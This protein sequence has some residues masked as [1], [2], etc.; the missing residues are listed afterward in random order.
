MKSTSAKTMGFVG[1]IN[2]AQG[3]E[4]CGAMSVMG[5]KFARL[6]VRRIYPKA[7]GPSN[8]QE[9]EKPGTRRVLSL[10]RIIL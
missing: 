6:I 1:F 2:R 4:R 10:F 5:C 8:R 9:I 7:R 3:L